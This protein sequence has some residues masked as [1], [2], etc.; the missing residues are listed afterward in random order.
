MSN[1]IL[2]K[3]KSLYKAL[4]DMLHNPTLHISLIRAVPRMAEIDPDKIIMMDSLKFMMHIA[5]ADGDISQRE[6]NII[7]YITDTYFTI[8]VLEN[9]IND[10]F[11]D[12]I[13]EIPLSIKLFC[14]LENLLYK[15]GAAADFDS[16]ILNILITYFSG[17]GVLISEADGY[18]SRLERLEI[19]NYLDTIKEYA[20][21][22]TLSPFFE[23]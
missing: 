4:I 2:V 23:F 14:E 17:L 19:E 20:S 1:E 22:H 8:E 18:N 3:I 6:V 16:S 21:K 11:L 12:D 13:D 9:L 5:N 7:S 15:N 10:D